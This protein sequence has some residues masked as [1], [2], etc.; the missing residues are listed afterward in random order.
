[1]LEPMRSP[2]PAFV[3]VYGMPEDMDESHV[4]TCLVQASKELGKPEDK[5][6]FR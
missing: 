1:M 3:V 2:G 5:E 6:R 4:P